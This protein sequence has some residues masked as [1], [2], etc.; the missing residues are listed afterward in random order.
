MSYFNQPANDFYETFQSRDEELADYEE[1]RYLMLREQE[2]TI[3][4]LPEYV[5]TPVVRTPDVDPFPTLLSE[6]GVTAP[7]AAALVSM[8]E[9]KPVRIARMQGEL[10]PEVA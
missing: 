1:R 9:R 7:E 3:G 6:A 5:Y 8:I 2:E 4:D 10:F